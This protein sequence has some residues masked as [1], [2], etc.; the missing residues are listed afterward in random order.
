MQDKVGMG[1]KERQELLISVFG[2]NGVL[3]NDSLEFE[4]NVD[5]LQPKVEKVSSQLGNYLRKSLCPLIT[6]HR[7]NIRKSKC[8]YLKWT[9]NNAESGN[10]ILKSAV[11]WKPQ[12]TDQLVQTLYEIVSATYKDVKRALIGHG[13]YQV[14]DSY[15][16]YAIPYFK[17]TEL[18]EEKKEKAIKRYMT[19]KTVSKKFDMLTN[20]LLQVPHTQAQGIKKPRTAE[21]KRN[22]KTTTPKNEFV[23]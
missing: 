5:E 20:G 11:N 17:W 1:K 21:T 22:A 3:M 16:A 15:N 13:N 23:C 12:P 14:A 4:E 8:A 6:D 9:N 18:T 10:H 2:D 7:N 19:A